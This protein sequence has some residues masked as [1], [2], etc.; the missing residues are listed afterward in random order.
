MIIDE[1]IAY[2]EQLNP[3]SMKLGLDRMK[4][5]LNYLGQPQDKIKCI[6]IA[7]TNGKGSVSAMLTNILK[8]ADYKVGVFNSPHLASYKEYLTI[9]GQ[10]ASDDI[11]CEIVEVV[12]CASNKMVVDGYEQPTIFEV[13]TA[14]AYLFFFKEKVDYAI[15]EVGLGG[16]MDSTNVI[17]NPLLAIIT[18][19]DYDHINILGDT[20]EAIAREKAGIIKKGCPVITSNSN[21]DVLNVIKEVAVKEKAPFYQVNPIYKVIVEKVNGS[22]FELNQMQY[23]VSLPGGVQVLNA[24]LVIKA[25][26]IMNEE[27]SLKVTSE[28]VQKGLKSVEWMGRLEKIKE[29]PDVIL[30]GC[31]NDSSVDN[32]VDYIK[33]FYSKRRVILLTSMLRDKNYERNL[34]KL[35]SVARDA[36]ITE[37]PNNP[38]GLTLEEME[39]A[40]SIHESDNKNIHYVR[41]Y[42]S[43]LQETLGLAGES[44]VIIVAGSFHLVGKVRKILV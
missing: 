23:F 16:R 12:K 8:V 35:F 13:L 26:E 10:M 41:A 25:I 29:Q 30:D 36:V 2:L 7:G 3:F 4:T 9:N 20:I 40:L 44:D 19:I 17:R 1:A 22:L 42:Q 6:H 24:A 37:I 31:H 5:L 27:G 18:T 39:K 33:K 14:M 38:R 43:A 15:V 34:R 21:Q 32:L 11:F 28:Q